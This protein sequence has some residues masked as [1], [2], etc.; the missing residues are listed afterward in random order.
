[1]KIGAKLIQIEAINSHNMGRTEALE[2]DVAMMLL[3]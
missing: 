1:M 3:S 2:V